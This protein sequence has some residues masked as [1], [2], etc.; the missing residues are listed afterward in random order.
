MSAGDELFED[1]KNIRKTLE[2]LLKQVA[3]LSKRAQEQGKHLSRAELDEVLAKVK[4]ETSF[5]IRYD[6]L[7]DRIQ[8]HLATP[9]KVDAVLVSGLQRVEQ[10]VSQ[11]PRSVSIEGQV[12]GF[13]NWRVGALSVGLPLVLLLLLLWFPGIFSRV[14]KAD[15]ENLKAQY[16]HDEKQLEVLRQMR[17]KLLKDAPLIAYRYFPYANDPKLA[18][19]STPAPPAPKRKQPK[20]R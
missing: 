2:A 17:G 11:I 5:S 1:I 6:L 16:V 4:Q 8:P 7:A 19:A 9:D 20:G 14:P 15:Y 13:T 12:W 10:V 18:S 3:G